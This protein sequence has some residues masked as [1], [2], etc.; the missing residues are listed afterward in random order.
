MD[1]AVPALLAGAAEISRRMGFA[2][3]P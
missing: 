3:A 2:G 1:A